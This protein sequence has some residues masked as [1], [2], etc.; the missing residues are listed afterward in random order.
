MIGEGL[1]NIGPSFASVMHGFDRLNGAA[2]NI[3]NGINRAEA[4]IGAAALQGIADETM[5]ELPELKLIPQAAAQLD[6]RHADFVQTRPV[7]AFGA[8]LA[9]P[10]LPYLFGAMMGGTG[11]N[12]RVSD[13]APKPAPAKP[14]EAQAAPK[15]ATPI[16]T[17]AAATPKPADATPRPA[18]APAQPTEA[19]SRHAAHATD[20]PAGTP[21]HTA[22]DN[23]SPHSDGQTREIKIARGMGYWREAHLL[24]PEGASNRDIQKLARELE[25]LN[26]NKKLFFGKTMIIPA[27]ITT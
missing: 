3:Q 15:P 19:T 9:N 27:E 16:P 2:S 12:H 26:H 1:K 14:V 8:S 6:Q 23:S 21:A 18:A 22:R 25:T 13:A 17:P 24:L 4:E 11:A 7:I 10:G 20:V 5:K